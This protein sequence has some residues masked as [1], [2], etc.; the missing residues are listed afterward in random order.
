MDELSRFQLDIL[1]VLAAQSRHGMAVKRELERVYG[2]TVHHGR[3]Y[4]NLDSLIDDGL[5][6]KDARNGRTNEYSVT[7]TGRKRLTARFQF[8]HDA[9][10]DD[11]TV[12]HDGVARRRDG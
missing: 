10:T 2:T 8:L 12:P 7:S 9:L 3:L 11:E 6:E 5:V 4:P 1:T